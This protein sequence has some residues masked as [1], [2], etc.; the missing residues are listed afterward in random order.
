M[1]E[2][3][4]RQHI[5]TST[6]P[7]TSHSDTCSFHKRNWNCDCVSKTSAPVDTTSEEFKRANSMKCGTFVRIRH[8]G[9]LPDNGEIKQVSDDGSSAVAPQVTGPYKFSQLRSV[10]A[11]PV[12]PAPVAG[13][14]RV[15]LAIVDA[16]LYRTTDG[17]T[18]MSK[19]SAQMDFTTFC[20][21]NGYKVPSF[22]FPITLTNTVKP[23]AWPSNNNTIP[24]FVEAAQAS[25]Q[26]D[27]SDSADNPGW[28]LE[29]CLDY[30]SVYGMTNVVNTP[31]NGPNIILIHANS[32]SFQDLGTAIGQAFALGADVVSLSWG[33]P[34]FVGEASLDTYF[35]NAAAL[36]GCIV[37]STGDNGYASYPAISSD[38]I[39]VGGTGLPTAA[40]GT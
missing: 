29:E 2:R 28:P 38:C 19:S 21:Q 32:S 4:S 16:Y 36:K 12:Y 40:N 9:K 37:A 33:G 13:K 26:L 39:G 27:L 31:S 5:P 15:T 22:L 20:N 11:Y 8:R 1:T 25:C 24:Y 6:D 14:R 17:S 23:V 34:E 10:Y 7:H 3:F 18:G 30:Q 35:N